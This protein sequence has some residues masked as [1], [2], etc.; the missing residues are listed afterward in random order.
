MDL[1]DQLSKA[2]ES[3]SPKGML[4]GKPEPQYQPVPIQ[5]VPNRRLKEE[6]EK[7]KN[8][9]FQESD[10]LLRDHSTPDWLNP[11]DTKDG[12]KKTDLDL[13]Y[14][15]LNQQRSLLNQ[16]ARLNP[17][18]LAPLSGP[19]F[20][21]ESKS[22]NDDK[23][24]DKLKGPAGRLQDLLAPN[25]ST[26]TAPHDTFSDLFRPPQNTLTPEQVEAHKNLMDEYRK[27]LAGT[28]P[29]VSLAPLNSAAANGNPQMPSLPGAVPHLTP[30]TPGMVG[31]IYNPAII[32]DRNST[33]LNQWNPM[34]APPKV[35]P[36]KPSPLI[37]PPIEAPRRKF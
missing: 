8:W 29:A 4:D 34:Y 18:D 16:K 24:P 14:E 1:E 12:K 25:P 17:D 3:V 2:L 23:L 22:R 10:D 15:R 19:S 30:S 21:D 32:P 37:E 6:R 7:R 28:P 27:I 9:M 26:V 11:F 5:V 20:N 33:V 36:P 31:S 13:F 35:E